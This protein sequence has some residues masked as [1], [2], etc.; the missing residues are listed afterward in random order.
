LPADQHQTCHIPDRWAGVT[1]ARAYLRRRSPVRYRPAVRTDAE[2][3]LGD[4]LD[5]IF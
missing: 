5:I 4:P 3:Q 2:C 1:P